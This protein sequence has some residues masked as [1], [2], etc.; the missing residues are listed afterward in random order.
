M[1]LSMLVSPPLAYTYTYKFLNFFAFAV[2]HAISCGGC[3]GGELHCSHSRICLKVFLGRIFLYL[4]GGGV[5][6]RE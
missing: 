2:F 3:G 6:C 5:L 4:K 1:L